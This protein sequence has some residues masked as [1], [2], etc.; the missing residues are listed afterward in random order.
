[1]KLRRDGRFDEKLVVVVVVVV[2]KVDTC[3]EGRET[4]KVKRGGWSFFDNKSPQRP[5]SLGGRKGWPGEGSDASRA[6][7]DGCV[8][9]PRG[10]CR[11][12]VFWVGDQMAMKKLWATNRHKAYVCLL[13]RANGEKSMLTRPSVG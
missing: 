11:C 2:I 13:W 6:A 1:V 8:A 10:L 3:C 7:A 4:R 12:V 9:W 5:H